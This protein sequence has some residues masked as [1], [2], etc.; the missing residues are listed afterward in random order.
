M[1]ARLVVIAFPAAAVTFALFFL[2]ARLIMHPLDEEVAV[3]PSHQL[4]LYKPDC[5]NLRAQVDSLLERAK[6]CSVD[7]DC[8]HYPCS[9]SA[10]G[11][12][13]STEQ[14]LAVLHN[15]YAWCGEHQII[16]YCGSTRPVCVEGICGVRV[17][18]EA[19]LSTQTPLI[20]SRSDL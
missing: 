20:P 11:R 7:S 13:S 16:P 12:N 14:Y 3:E 6:I 19:V 17:T 9:C 10:L 4:V 8:F 1:N 18:H 15:L 5:I 2:T